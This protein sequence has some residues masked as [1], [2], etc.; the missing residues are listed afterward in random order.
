MFFIFFKLSYTN[1]EINEICGRLNRFLRRAFSLRKLDLSFNYLRTRIFS[2][3]RGLVQPL[4]YLN[5]QDCRLD[6]TD[7]AYINTNGMLKTLKN[8]RELNLSMND[9]SQ[10]NS[11]VINIIINCLKLNC[12]S[13]SYCQIPIDILCQQL[14]KRLAENQQSQLKVVCIQPF[15]PPPLHELMDILHAFSVL[16]NLQRL[17]FLP[18]VYAF[19]GSNDYERENA[20]FE[21]YQVCSSILDARGRSDIDFLGIQS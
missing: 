13:I 18:S 11:I 1:E 6:S 2:I 8:C 19:P 10:S 17:Y 16:K 3:L 14:A 12:L 21:V 4:E 20:A 7:I 9:F 15:V 5:L